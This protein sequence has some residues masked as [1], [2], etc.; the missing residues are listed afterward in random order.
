MKIST[1]VHKPQKK[2]IFGLTHRY[3]HTYVLSAAYDLN[4][5]KNGPNETNPIEK[6][7]Q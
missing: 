1:H 5:Q 6:T 3:Q 7:Y 4:T 2:T